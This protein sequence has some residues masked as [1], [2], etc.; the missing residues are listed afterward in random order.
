[1][2]SIA[3]TLGAR[4]ASPPSQSYVYAIEAMAQC[5]GDRNALHGSP[6]HLRRSTCCNKR[7]VKASTKWSQRGRVWDDLFSPTGFY[8]SQAS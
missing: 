8:T 2:I 3:L 5:L 7:H 6:D 1:M 4:I